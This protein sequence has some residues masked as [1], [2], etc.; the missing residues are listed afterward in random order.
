MK[1]DEQKREGP[2]NLGKV[3]ADL[4]ITK[5]KNEALRN[6]LRRESW[7]K[8]I[9]LGIAV[10]YMIFAWFFM[11]EDALDFLEVAGFLILPLAC[12]WFSE[13]VGSY[14]GPTFGAGIIWRKSHPSLIRFMGWALLLFPLVLVIFMTLRGNTC[15]P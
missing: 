12:I 5:L 15:C 3:L 11:C 13:A 1:D 8:V 2:E 9:S 7:E 10:F 4:E 14:R 6:K